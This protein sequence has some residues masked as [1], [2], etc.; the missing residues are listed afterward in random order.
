MPT[1]K[2]TRVVTPSGV[3][4]AMIS[5]SDGVI[6][7]VAPY[8][9]FVFGPVEDWG[10]AVIMPGLVDIHVHI[11]EPG[12]TE[13][14][15]FRTATRAAAAGGVTTLVDMPLNSAPVTTTLE[16]LQAK[17]AAA[18][19]KLWVDVG[20][21]GGL[22]PE[23]AENLEPLLDAGVLGLKAFLVHSGIDDFPAAGERELRAA[24]PLLARAGM[25]LLVHA[26]LEGTDGGLPPGQPV[27][28]YR[29][30]LASRPPTW[31]TRAIQMVLRLCEECRCPV[32]IVHLATAEALPMLRQARAVGLPVTVETCPHYLYFAAEQIPDAS[33]QYKCAP[34]IRE[35]A[36]R[37]ALWGALLNGD[38]DLIA[39]DHSPCPP[40]L[41]RLEEGDYA[42][43]W[44]GI[45]S[46]QLQLP[47]VWSAGRT[48]GATLEQVAVWMSQ[49]PAEVMGL[50]ATKGR[51]AP[52]FDAD[53]LVWNPESRFMVWPEKLEHRHA[54]TPYAGHT[55]YGEVLATYLR[56]E[57]I[58]RE[59]A[60]ASAPSGRMLHR[61][62]V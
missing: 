18:E 46:L 19:G 50:S 51:L 14:E 11:N 31:E 17:Q 3:H 9:A 12:R 41:K 55:L 60:F 32:H 42:A 8:D 48:R 58:F 47:A 39:S 45:A 13:W 49:K 38:I 28:R 56:G 20:F 25:P 10:D 1:L 2:S 4:P 7:D 59:G 21:Y 37:E 43:A 23:N 54:V 29:D 57:E 40:E 27:T 34:P 26:E 24:L 36:T 15:G 53:L 62:R 6:Q 35:V 30:Y 52:G 5:V 44:G 22:V 61:G 33:T 16:A